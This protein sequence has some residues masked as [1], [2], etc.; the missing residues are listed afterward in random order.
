MSLAGFVRLK[1]PYAKQDGTVVD[2]HMQRYSTGT[3][4]AVN[5]ERLGEIWNETPSA[6]GSIARD[7]IFRNNAK[8]EGF[9]DRDV[10][11]FLRS[12]I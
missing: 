3:G 2:S 11:D 8:S 12:M 1:R 7:D 5:W 10:D 9:T 4:R 6:L